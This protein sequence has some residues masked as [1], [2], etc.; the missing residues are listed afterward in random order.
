MQKRKKILV[1]GL[2][3]TGTLTAI[4]LAGDFDIVGVGTKP[5]LLSGQ[6]L[7]TRLA[8]PARWKQNYL[9]PYGR[10]PRLDGIRALHGEITRL[11]PSGNKA[12]I[13]LANGETVEE[14]YD[15]LLIAS[16]VNN[17]FWRNNKVQDLATIEQE[18]EQKSAQFSAADT[19]AIIGGGASGVSVASN[20]TQKYPHKAIHF[21]FSQ[22]QP[23][24]GYHPKVRQSIMKHLL[25]RGV[26]L[27]PG[28]R[29]IV[30]EDIGEG[31]T[32]A[33]LFFE[34]STEPFN[35]DLCL[36]T[37]GK[38]QP[39]SHFL[40]DDM[41]DEQGFVKADAFLRVPGYNNIFTVGDIAASDPNRSSAR[42]AGYVTVAHNMRCF[43]QQR[44]EAMKRY[45]ASP[46]R[47]GS[48]VGVQQNGLRVY[49]PNGS[50]MRFPRWA[51][52]TLL[53][54]LIVHKGIYKGVR[55]PTEQ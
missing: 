44:P 11:D 8:D 29:A 5:C 26:K 47:W 6:E 28:Q 34:N 55:K 33:P 50:S 51:I 7:G 19:I 21:F 37:I 24:P 10:Y 18:L 12:V 3:D 15:A 30:P 27:H 31:L 41:L 13:S 9:M 4:H 43:L 22:Q 25:V 45:K 42:N 16:G 14:T 20:L 23:L 32:N 53:F 39:N 46:H 52:N 38:L 48:I 49:L 35:A 36:W 17:G 2:G 40:P 54:P 1:A